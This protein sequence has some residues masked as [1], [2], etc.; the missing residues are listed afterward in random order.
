MIVRAGPQSGGAA[1]RLF[2]DRTLDRD[3]TAALSVSGSP[4]AWEVGAPGTAL[5]ACG[6]Q[7]RSGGGR[8]AAGCGTVARVP[9][10][11][12][13]SPSW[14]GMARERHSRC[15]RSRGCAGPKAGAVY[16]DGAAHGGPSRRR[17]RCGWDCWRRMSKSRSSPGV[18]GG[19]GGKASDLKLWQREAA[20]MCGSLWGA[21]GRGPRWFR[22]PPVAYLSGE[23]GGRRWRRCSLRS[24]L[25]VY[26]SMNP[27]ITWIRLISWGFWNCFGRCAARQEGDRDAARSDRSGAFSD[28][29]VL[30]YG[31]GRWAAGA[32]ENLPTAETLSR[33]LTSR[34]CWTW[35][36]GGAGS[37]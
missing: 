28:R 31:D 1:E 29:A 36:G 35:E 37:S 23:C 11:G 15:I 25:H 8:A 4:P 19:A 13:S 22:A 6:P 3:A 27:P 18:G 32:A 34:R 10:R 9:C 21:D 14:G 26:C 7:R 30:L 2:R 33:A 5:Y 12:N 20:A 17:S 16:L 24:L